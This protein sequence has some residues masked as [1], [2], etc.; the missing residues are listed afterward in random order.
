MYVL[1]RHTF[2]VDM[3]ISGGNYV[4][5]KWLLIHLASQISCELKVHVF[6]STVEAI[7]LYGS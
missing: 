3:C 7:L 6:R 5:L 4:Q 2:T 1:I